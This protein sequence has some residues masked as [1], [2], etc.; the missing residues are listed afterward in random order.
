[1]LCLEDPSDENSYKNFDN[2]FLYVYTVE[3]GLKIFSM[4]FIFNKKAYLRLFWNWMDFTIVITGYIPFVLQNSSSINITGLRSLRVLRPLRAI[5][6]LKELKRIL[7]ALVK[8]L[9]DFLNVMVI[10]SFF[11][12]FFGI[13]ALQLFS[14][15][16]KKR[17]FQASTGL[18][19]Q[20]SFDETTIGILCGTFICPG[21]NIC[22][23]IFTNPY[24]N[25]INFDNIFW[26]M[27]MIF[28]SFTTNFN[29]FF[30][31]QTFNPYASLCFF[32][33]ATFVGIFL[34][35]NLMLSVISSAYSADEEKKSRNINKIEREDVIM[36]TEEFKKLKFN[37]TSKFKNYKIMIDFII[38]YVPL[39]LEDVLPSKEIREK[40]KII[41]EFEKDYK[42]YN[43]KV[44]CKFKSLTPHDKKMKNKKISKW[45]KRLTKITPKI[46]DSTRAKEI[47]KN[48]KRIN[49]PLVISNK[50]L[51]FRKI[52]AFCVPQKEI[53]IELQNFV[54][55][56]TKSIKGCEN[57]VIEYERFN[58]IIYEHIN[59]P[60]PIDLLK[61]FDNE[62]L[63]D[64]LKVDNFY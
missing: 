60:N 18:I 38:E 24:Y 41:L 33:L 40:Q 22:G 48:N 35:L 1:M 8:G 39:S 11:L 42:A 59:N 25:V 26:S 57:L 10:Y 54:E 58:R 28:Q 19:L 32:M 36:T 56:K 4:G 37:K 29:Y 14:G 9:P 44:S 6:F 61:E 23:K 12:C 2:F 62:E 13:S 5:S 20:Q 15:I 55:E 21:D 46:F 50:L 27:V 7:T 52:T 45:K 31:V 63:Y 47:M 51:I 3:M 30:I 17:C 53:N 34:L 64:H 43:F 49:L 16:L